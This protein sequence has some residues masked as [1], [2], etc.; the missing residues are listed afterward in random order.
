[1]LL[2]VKFRNQFTAVGTYCA[3]VEGPTLEH[4]EANHF[5][6]DTFGQRAALVFVFNVLEEVLEAMNIFE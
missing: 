5:P 3:Q 6:L 4:V 1:M 2:C